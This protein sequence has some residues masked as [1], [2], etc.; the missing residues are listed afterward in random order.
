[1]TSAAPATGGG[2]RVLIV[3]W[4]FPP[5][6]V[7]GALRVSKFA[8]YLREEGW[9]VRVVTAAP[10]L[11]PFPAL[12]PV[13]FPEAETVRVRYRDP[14]TTLERRGRQLSAA[15]AAER[16]A[17]AEPASVRASLGTRVLRRVAR[18]VLKVVPITQVRIPDR[19]TLW[20]RP[21]FRAARALCAS[22][23]PDVILSSFGPPGSHIVASWLQRETG[24]PWVADY[25]DLWTESISS[26]RPAVPSAVERSVERRVLRRA[27]AIT[28]IS[29]PFARRLQALHGKPVETIYNGYDEAAYAVPVEPS[30][31]FVITYT[32]LAEPSHRDPSPLFA[33]VRRLRDGGTD[34][35][36][37]PRIRFVGSS[38]PGYLQGLAERHG[39]AG[40]V[41]VGGTVPHA[42]S[43][44]LQKRSTVLLMLNWQGESPGG[45][46]TGKLLEYVGAGRPILAIGPHDA[47]VSE[48]LARTGAGV[49]RGDGAGVEALLGEWM[50]LHA[51]TGRLELPARTEEVARFGRRAQTHVLGELLARVA[52]GRGAGDGV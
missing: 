31:E 37:L 51:R 8:R 33:A 11:L 15:A 40:L 39:I 27:A 50:D 23:R 16:A 5:A 30:P 3:T 38:P 36:R 22:W 43:V 17:G 41:E 26:P 48:V 24:V 2:R 4:V 7:I 52:D 12:L 42:E 21:A 13:E 14:L 49:W 1:M 35:S 34:P 32:G 47:G 10:E 18:G 28:T 6:Q 9:E 44:H 45:V 29:D 46:L 20:Y 25:R 19:S